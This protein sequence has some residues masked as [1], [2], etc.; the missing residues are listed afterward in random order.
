MKSILLCLLGALSFWAAGCGTSQPSA[1]TE[2]DN[3]TSDAGQSVRVM[4]YNVENLFDTLD[5]PDTRDG[6]FLPDGSYSWNSY[7]YYT[8]L[9]RIS[10]VILNTGAWNVPAVIGLCEVENRQVLEDLLRTTPLIKFD[11]GIVH[12]ES[13]DERGIDVALL[14]QKEIYS[15]IAHQTLTVTFPDDPDDRT[16]DVL[17]AVGTIGPDTLHFFV[18]HWPSR[19]GGQEASE[20]KRMRAAA[21]VRQA[22]DSLLATNPNAKIIL[23]GDFNDGP[24][25]RSMAEV[26]QAEGDSTQL[27]EGELYNYMLPFFKKGIGTHKYRQEWNTLDQF[28]VSPGLL[29]AQE[30]FYTDWSSATIVR[31]EFLLEEDPYNPGNR[32]YRALLG[33]RWHG[34]YSDHLPIILELKYRSDF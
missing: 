17:H 34:G 16:R 33:P 22:V 1:T 11:Y 3:L 2:S 5:S 31:E 32:P 4:F 12:E 27:E 24:E 26:L 10:K 30:G 23:M 18:N 8:K 29:Q 9:K 19:S 25:N 28:V 13:P 6:S 15:P 21:V 14:Y 20:P 7:K